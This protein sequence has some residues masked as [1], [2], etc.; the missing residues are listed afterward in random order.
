MNSKHH[1]FVAAAVLA[2]AI[3]TAGCSADMFTQANTAL[4]TITTAG[5]AIGNARLPTAAIAASLGGM[6]MMEALSADGKEAKSSGIIAAGSGNIIAAGGLNYWLNALE[7]G[8][9]VTKP[10]KGDKIDGSVTYSSAPEGTK[11]TSKISKFTCTS[12]GYEIEAKDGTFSF[13]TDGNKVHCSLSGSIKHKDTSISLKDLTF[14]TVDPL[15]ANIDK[16]GGFT[17]ITKDG[18]DEYKFVASIGVKDGKIVAEADSFKNGTKSG[19]KVK[20]DESNAA[21]QVGADGADSANDV[22]KAK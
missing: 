17:L 2:S 19:D 7:P 4:K 18:N 1:N 6:K 9:D 3:V 21:A 13:D 11:W 16:F 10:V 22:T 15:P 20:F 14:D 12:Q 8:K 5:K